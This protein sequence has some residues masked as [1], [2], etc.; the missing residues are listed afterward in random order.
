MDDKSS[1]FLAATG[2]DAR[3][4]RFFVMPK[5]QPAEADER[6]AFEAWWSGS[7]FTKFKDTAEAAFMAGKARAALSS[8]SAP[9]PVDVD[10]LAQFIRGLKEWYSM[11]AGQLAERIT[12]WL[13]TRELSS[14]SAQPAGATGAGR[15]SPF[16]AVAEAMRLASLMGGSI[17]MSDVEKT[18]HYEQRL[19]S[20]LI[21]FMYTAAQPVREPMSADDLR[22]PKNG[23]AWRVEWWNES[24]RLMLPTSEKL[25]SISAY[26]NGTK[27]LTIKRHHGICKE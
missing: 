9:K 5:A 18:R 13:A 26:N 4:G 17:G 11:G 27:V 10:E 24:M 21:E 15:L 12:E 8:P 2:G 3:D 1:E 23:A 25:D 20:H 22:E 19:R 6:A 16:D 14:P 7:G